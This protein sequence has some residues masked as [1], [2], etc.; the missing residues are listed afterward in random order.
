MVRVRTPSFGRNV[1]CR[2]SPRCMCLILP[3]FREW[4]ILTSSGKS[5]A[6]APGPYWYSAIAR[7]FLRSSSIPPQ[8]GRLSF[9]SRF[10]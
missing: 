8:T 4:T 10:A 7:I 3:V 2:A 6:P 9:I 5:A 1:A